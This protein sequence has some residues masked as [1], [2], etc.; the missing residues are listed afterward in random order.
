MC[1]L[2]TSNSESVFDDIDLGFKSILDESFH[3]FFGE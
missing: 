2:Q 1:D 3:P